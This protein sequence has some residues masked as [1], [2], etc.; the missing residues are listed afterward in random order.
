MQHESPWVY[1]LKEKFTLFYVI[2]SPLLWCN[3]KLSQ[4]PEASA[5]FSSVLSLWYCL[6]YIIQ[7]CSG[8]LFHP[9]WY[10]W[11]RQTIAVSISQY[12]SVT[13]KKKNS[14]QNDL[15]ESISQTAS[16]KTARFNLT[17]VQDLMQDSFISLSSQ[18]PRTG[19]CF[20]HY[21]KISAQA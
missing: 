5:F 21:Q 12:N 18:L 9:R 14:S 11:F 1:P 19:E 16:T 6:Y 7:R 3:S 8:Y 4:M 10:K 20:F 17:D 2:I 15:D 13:K